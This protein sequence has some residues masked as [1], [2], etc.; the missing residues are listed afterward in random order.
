MEEYRKTGNLSKA[1]MRADLDRKT[2]RKY[3]C[4]GQLPSQMKTEYTWKTRKDQFE[5]HWTDHSSAATLRP[6]ASNLDYSPTTG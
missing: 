5:E 1:A 3:V 2:V 4:S 6:T